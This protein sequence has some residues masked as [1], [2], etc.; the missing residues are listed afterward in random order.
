MWEPEIKD[1]GKLNVKALIVIFNQAR[2]RFEA[3]ASTS[4]EITKKTQALAF[5]IFAFLGAFVSFKSPMIIST[6]LAFVL[7]VLLLGALVF[8]TF[9]LSPRADTILRG[10]PPKEIFTD[11][12]DSEKWTIEEQENLIYYREIIR[13]QEKI[14]KMKGSISTRSLFFKIALGCSLLILI[15]LST[16]ILISVSHL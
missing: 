13:Y 1:W 8:I 5:A 7:C 9:L 6:E 14:N 12:F 3:H 2:E 15:L 11:D 4:E 16:K 10:S